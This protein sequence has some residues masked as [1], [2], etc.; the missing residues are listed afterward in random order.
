MPLVEFPVPK[1]VPTIEELAQNVG[2]TNEQLTYLLNGYL[3]VKNIRA[4]G[5]ETRNLKAGSIV[6]DKLAAGAVT[7]EKITV[8]QLSAITADLGHITAGLIEAVEIFGSYIATSTGYPRCEMSSTGN[9]FG[10]FLDPNNSIEVTPSYDGS[11]TLTFTSLGTLRGFLKA[12]G[13]TLLLQ[14]ITGSGDIQI[15]S[16]GDL[17]LYASTST[18]K[19]VIFDSWSRMK[20]D[21]TGHTLQQDLDT[22]NSNISSLSSSIS[23]LFSLYSSLDSRVSALESP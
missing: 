6:T 10:A 22:M 1:R 16:G 2:K 5:I 17:K 7:A 11:P 9:L 18:G 14:T 3:D 8:S 15:G 21:D 20:N 23:T 13:S 4:E 12:I 19:Y